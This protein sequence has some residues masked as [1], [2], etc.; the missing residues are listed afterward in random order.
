MEQKFKKWIALSL[1]F[2]AIIPAAVSA[3][4][5]F[6]DPLWC[7]SISHR[8]N[9]KQD[10]FNERIQKTNYITFHGLD[11]DAIIMGSSTS[12]SFN[13]SSF[14]GLKIYNYSINAL[15]PSEYTPYLRYARSHNKRDFTYIFLGLDFLMSTHL[16]KPFIEPEKVFSDANYP[17]YR[18][19]VL[20]SIDTLKM[21]RKNLLNA[22]TVRHIYYDREG[23]K[24]IER[25]DRGTAE[26]HMTALMKI[27][28]D[29]D[30]AVSFRKYQYD[31]NYPHILRQVKDAFP[32][33]TFTPYTTPVIRPF[34]IAMVKKGLTDDYLRW[35]KDI[36]DVFGECYHFMYPNRVS[37]NYLE[38]FHDPN[39]CYPDIC[40]LMAEAMYAK[41]IR[42][43]TQFGMYI[44]RD[45]LKDRLA[46]LS[47][48]MNALVPLSERAKR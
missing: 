25:L 19:K 42:G 39:H 31:P 37:D 8:F 17:L 16:P 46:L 6:M 2:A 29:S 27:F 5:Y 24:Y 22:L 7:F 28:E 4:N 14:K 23:R 21:S 3:F 43:V 26:L 12:T 32:N 34:M 41:Q 13:P 20:M 48:M 38:N 1:L 45:N 15:M 18:P 35:V 10:D 9:Q 11:C 33:T 36:V 47:S 44:N 30:S 40:D